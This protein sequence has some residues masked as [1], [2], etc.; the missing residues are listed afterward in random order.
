MLGDLANIIGI[1][2]VGLILIA[3]VLLQLRKMNPA[4]ILFSL[5]NVVGSFFILVSLIVYWNLSAFLMEVTWII[6]SLYGMF[7]AIKTRKL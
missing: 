5:L 1:I 4:G 2:G 3:Y 7:K 6:I